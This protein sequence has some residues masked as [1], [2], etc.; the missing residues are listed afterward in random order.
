MV[1]KKIWILSVFFFLSF[2]VFGQ[3]E[4]LL[5]L[6]PSELKKDFQLLRTALEK[7]HAGLYAYT[8]EKEMNLVFEK[9]EKS[10]NQPM[11][12]ID[13]FRKISELLKPIG[14]GHTLFI[15]QK[16]Y[17]E[18]IN[19]RLPRFPF[20][21]YW[22]RENLYV[23]RNLSDEKNIQPGTIIKTINGEK[24]SDVYQ[25]L[26]DK[27][28]R[29]GN[30]NAFPREKV[31]IG[32][33]RFYA[34]IKGTPEY[35]TMDLIDLEGKENQLKIKGLS[36]SQIGEYYKKRYP[37]FK[38]KSDK[39]PLRFTINNGIGVLTVTTFSKPDIKKS[40]QNYKDFFEKTFETIKK[41][42]LKNLIVDVRDNGGGYPE[43]VIDLHRYLSETPN[44]PHTVSHTI[45]RNLPNQKYYKYGFWEYLELRFA[46]RL[47]KQGDK[48]LVTRGRK[49]NKTIL[50]PKN[51]FKGN[52]K[53]LFN[54]NSFSATV[55]FL[56]LLKNDER[57][58][59][60][61]E[62][63]GGSPHQSTAWMFPEFILPHSKIRAIIPLVQTKTTLKFEDTN[64]GIVP[65][66]FVR[67]SIED[68]VE[69]KDAVM[70]FA[71]E[72]I[73]NGK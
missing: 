11:T 47:R 5:L 27:Y 61:G 24:A 20:A 53:I 68:V 35:F 71:L 42:Q 22:H 45:T 59:F 49:K 46:F 40:G 2:V 12:S 60:I 38:K 32:F 3:N 67:N 57:G 37:N 70:E 31:I 72:L 65:H 36:M 25:E 58:V 54:A 21:V 66:H 6:Q 73:R 41:E 55:S 64:E 62:T 44:Y 17:M 7:T 13:F 56:G 9:M 39:L 18:A 33:S 29:D 16:E 52:L 15:P 19:N 43:V 4:E 69:G 50:S 28:T 26:V 63:A 51:V 8:S 1:T 48:Y 10:L 30:I 14:N 34:I 23:L